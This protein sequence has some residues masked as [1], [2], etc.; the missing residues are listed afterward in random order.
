MLQLT[1]VTGGSHISV[2]SSALAGVGSDAESMI[3]N[4]VNAWAT[5]TLAYLISAVPVS[6]ESTTPPSAQAP[7]SPPQK[8]SSGFNPTTLKELALFA[9]LKESEARQY[10]LYRHLLEVQASNVLNEL[11]CSKLRC[12]LAHNEKKKNGSGKKGRL[13]GDGLPVFLLGDEFYEKVVNF[14]A[15]QRQE[16]R[17]KAARQHAREE[18]AETLAE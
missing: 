13:M 12:Q 3:R 16:E 10:L 2:G 8:A 17:E 5:G 7:I 14:E 18:M 9:A 6:S 4:V 15:K 1:A 11:Y